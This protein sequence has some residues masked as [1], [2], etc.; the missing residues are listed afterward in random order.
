MANPYF[1]TS[2]GRFCILFPTGMAE[3]GEK[4]STLIFI[5]RKVCVGLRCNK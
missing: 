1:W 5:G 2:S 4:F 3:L